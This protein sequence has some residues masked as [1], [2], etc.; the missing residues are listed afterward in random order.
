MEYEQYLI[1]QNT[2]EKFT[3]REDIVGKFV[4]EIA[5]APEQNVHNA[6][7]LLS[8]LGIGYYVAL[9]VKA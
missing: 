3:G 8:E 7:T 5:A 2:I 6:K 1:Y 9:C 4:S